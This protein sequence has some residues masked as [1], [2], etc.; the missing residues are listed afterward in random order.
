[1]DDPGRVLRLILP[2]VPTL[3]STALWHSL[4]RSPTSS[5][6][7]LRTEL[8]V[9]VLKFMMGGAGRK[10]SPIGQVQR[11][12]CNDPGV[13]G[14]MW[15]AKATIKA[16]SEGDEGLREAVFKAVDEMK[17]ADTN[18]TKPKLVDT[19]VEWTG[20]RPDA[21]K[22]D[23][24]PDVSEEEKYK[25]MMAEPSRTS[26]TT[27]LYFH[28][29]AYYLADPATHR[30]LVSRLAKES[31]GRA[32]SVRYRLAPQ[33]AFP[34]QLLDALMVYLSL[35]YPPP[36]S[37]HEPVEAKHI[38]LAGDSAGGNLSFALLQFLLQLH[39]T[40]SNPTVR[41][42]GKDVPVPLPA[43]ATANSGW[44]DISRS[45]PS[46]VTN[47][48]WDYLP[49][50][51]DDDVLSHFPHDSAW[52]A[53]PPRG[54]LFCD[55]SMLDHPLISLHVAETWAG[56]PPLW[57]NTGE[58]MLTDEDK[59]LASRAA[60]QGVAVEYEEYEAMPHCF[61]MMLPTLKAA[62]RCIKSWGNFCRKA[63]EEPGSIK[64][65]GVYVHAKSLKEDS[66]D[67]QKIAPLPMDEVVKRLKEAKNKRLM[68]WEKEGKALPKPAL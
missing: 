40:S 56:A 3:A 45:M 15:I 65:T 33:A 8:T 60:Q 21:G 50:P 63:V 17:V 64:T 38:V 67:V 61:P 47:A 26:N 48:T 54:D 41:F 1:M 24:L 31:R 13:K 35:L 2:Q 25:Q 58:E 39:R 23:P 6:W 68:G 5:K 59:V 27:I 30:P 7:D 14:K 37:M 55:L 46:L 42:H 28:G 66:V 43:G 44:F 18:Y 53:N 16:P 52:P 57:M 9:Q 12:S 11:L 20:F 22:A 51:K 36:G 10:P 29:G 34:A 4:G 32:C 19:E 49:P 62:D